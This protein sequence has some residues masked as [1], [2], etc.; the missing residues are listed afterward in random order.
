MGEANSALP[1][2]AMHEATPTFIAG[3]LSFKERLSRR[4]AEKE[5]GRI[6]PEVPAILSSPAMSTSAGGNKSPGD[7]TPL[8]ES[9]MVPVQVPESFELAFQC[10]R[11][12]VNQHPV[13]EVMPVL[14]KSSQSAS[15]EEAVEE[16]K[17]CRSTVYPCHRS[18]ALNGGSNEN[19][20]TPAADISV[21]NAK[22]NAATLEEFKNMFSAYEKRTR[23]V[24]PRR[25]IKVCRR[26]LDFA[27]PLDRPGTPRENPSGQNTSEATP[28]EN[29]NSENPLSPAKDIENNEVGR[30]NLDPSDRS[31]D[32]EE[33]VDLHPRRMRS[34]TAREDSPFSKPMTEEEENIFW[35]EHEK[36]PK[37]RPRSL[38]E[39]TNVVGKL[40][41]KISTFGTFA[42]T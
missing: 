15:R 23:A 22:A 17:D 18:T 29:Q 41:A 20:N 37:S 25:T 24:L 3:F 2:P 26:R 14:L 9:A 1:T 30:I 33:D 19:L 13:A 6:Q 31:D 39:N 4:S 16:M 10:H 38:A 34:R 28:V 27:T 5:G 36:W 8:A 42:I 11:S 35:V 7:A 12:E 32:T 21:A 40:L